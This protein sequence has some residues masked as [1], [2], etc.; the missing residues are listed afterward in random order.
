METYSKKNLKISGIVAFLSVLFGLSGYFITADQIF[1]IF[2][3]VILGI[4]FIIFSHDLA[5][6]QVIK[7]KFNYKFARVVYLF[8]GV[9]L[10]ILAIFGFFRL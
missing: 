10:L 3:A 7:Y 1:F 4:N 2:S 5:M 6:D 8:G 9:L